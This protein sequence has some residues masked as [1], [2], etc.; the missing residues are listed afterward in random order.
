MSEMIDM[1][2]SDAEDHMKKSIEALKAEFIKIRT[3][4]AH[5]S[6]LDHVQVDYYGSH[7]PINQA[8]SVT[9][10]DNRTLG[11]TPFEKNMVSTIEKAIRDSDLGLN[12][13]N[14]GN[15]LRVPL[16][17]LTEERRRELVKVVKHESETA[18][19]AIRNIRRKANGELKDL[20]KDKDISEDEERHAQD[21]IQKLTDKYVAEIEKALEAKETELMEV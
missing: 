1:I 14:V 11:V 12:P 7:V 21:I 17:P 3:G 16:P 2:K 20:L 13:T 15:L 5:T 8:A 10:L 9:V 19:V 18:R 6:L 4:R